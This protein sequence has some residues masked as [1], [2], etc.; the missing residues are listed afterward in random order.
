MDALVVA[1]MMAG[2]VAAAGGS[3]ARSADGV[4]IRYEVAGKG[5]LTVVL[6]HGWATDRHVWDQQVPALARR[7]RVVSLDLAGHGE[8]GRDRKQWTIE[9]LGEDVKA[10]ADAAG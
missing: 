10:A 8:S 7:H 4:P 5:E 2:A 1:V 3:S 9:S 6:V